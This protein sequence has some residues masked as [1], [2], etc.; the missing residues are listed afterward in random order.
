MNWT[1]RSPLVIR[2]INRQRAYARLPSRWICLPLP[3]PLRPPR[4]PC[5]PALLLP[6][7]VPPIVR[8]WARLSRKNCTADP[9]YAWWRTPGVWPTVAPP[10]PWKGWWE[11]PGW[12][13]H[14]PRN[15][16][17]TNPSQ[18]F[19]RAENLPFILFFFCIKNKFLFVL[20]SLV[21]SGSW[22]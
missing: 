11:G 22:G 14:R 8:E 20:L 2:K 13:P 3:C 12:T 18:L 21:V 17:R 6:G 9:R 4:S 16:T 1:L 15:Q 7:W 10:G 5:S 19:C